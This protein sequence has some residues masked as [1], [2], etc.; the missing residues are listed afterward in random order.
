MAMRYA[1]YYAPDPASALWLFGSSVLGYDARTG[2]N[3]PLLAPAG[4]SLADWEMATT[5][6]RRYGFHATLKA[7]FRLAL[8]MSEAALLDAVERSAE[9]HDWAVPEKA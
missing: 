1:I 6:P 8:G 5:D 3:V 4:I 9:T 7:P 2:R